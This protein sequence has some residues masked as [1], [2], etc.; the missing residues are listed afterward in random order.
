MRLKSCQRG[1]LIQIV[2]QRLSP[3]LFT[4][5]HQVKSLLED[6]RSTWPLGRRVREGND[7]LPGTRPRTVP[8]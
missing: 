3:N 2:S 5:P 7:Q 8:I 4:L 1:V 6:K